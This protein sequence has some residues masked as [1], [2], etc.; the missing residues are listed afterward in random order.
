M[1]TMWPPPASIIPGTTARMTWKVPFR[2]V[3][4]MRPK[5]AASVSVTGVGYQMPAAL[6]AMS[7]RPDLRA[8][9][10]DGLVDRR[11]VGHICDQADGAAAR[12]ANFVSRLTRIRLVEQGDART[13]GGKA[14]GNGTA[15]TR[16]GPRHQR[17]ASFQPHS[18]LL[19]PGQ[20]RTVV[21]CS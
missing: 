21:C 17:P 6:T 10:G 13:F 1:L 5:A 15:D 3:S 19:R 8:C 2:F 20:R 14:G 16:G 7:K 4:I 11:R 18:S 12:M 9:A